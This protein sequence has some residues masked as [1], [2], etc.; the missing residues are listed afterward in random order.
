MRKTILAVVSIAFL[1]AV[2]CLALPA[3]STSA[4][5]GGN[6]AVT[7]TR[8]VAPILFKNCV[9]CHKPNDIAPMS[10]VTYKDVRP[11]AR[12]I[13]EKVVTRE[14][15]P[16]HA[17]PHYGQFSNERRLSQQEIETISAWVD[18]G[19]KEG[20]QKDLPALPKLVTGWQIGT[21]DVVLSMDEEYLVR[22]NGPD[23]YLYF[24]LPT[25]FKEDKWIQAA[26]I[27][28]GNK[29]VVHHV[30]AF[31]QTPEM[32]QM[33][34]NISTARG[35]RLGP[36]SIFYQDGKLMRV[37]MDAPVNDDGCEHPETSGRREAG[38]GELPLLCGYAPGKDLDVFPPGTAK[39]VPAGSNI[40]FQV[41]YS[42]FSGG[43]NVDQKD[44]T[45]V[46]LVFSK[47]RPTKMIVTVGVLNH[48]FQIPPGDA[49]HRVAACFTLQRDVQV[50]DYMPHMHL[51]GKDMKYEAVYPDGKRETLLWVP[52][53]NFNWQ[54]VYW[55]KNPLNMPKGTKLIV[56]AHFDNS[57]G[58]KYNPDFTKAIRWGD[59]TYDEMMIGWLDYVV[60]RPR[61]HVIARVDPRV[62][63]SY[64]GQYQFGPGFTLTVTRDGDRL[65]GQLTGQPVIEIFPESDTHFFLKVIDGELDFVKNDKGEV[66]ELVFNSN[67][68]VLRG[69]KA[70][71]ATAKN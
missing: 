69:K 27:H 32:I 21:P 43:E 8:D 18:Q 51:R 38:L 65:M 28:P 39:R 56:T 68:R 52:Q 25:N 24:T 40:V 41:H 70:P 14:M 17:D 26:E 23:E 64:A 34:K 46:G 2:C 11:W 1:A 62:Y 6:T 4:D 33:A 13:R 59:P 60:D 58:N 29:R 54:T 37:K 61:D 48:S 55:L 20:D 71:A 30:I 3:S 9:E 36:N 35:N 42:N 15:P 7:F 16:W 66:T 10:L 67:G 63:D 12:S 5:G 44:R 31:I 19:A 47:E 57:K 22:A 49:D 50:V 53:F 45:S